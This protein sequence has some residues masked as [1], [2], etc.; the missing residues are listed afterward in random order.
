MLTLKKIRKSFA[1]RRILNGVS[2]SIGDGQRI[3]L[4]GQNGVGKSTLLKIIAGLEEADR[5]DVILKKGALV[6]Y[7]PQETTSSTKETMLDYL[8]N[9]SGLQGI[10]KKMKALEKELHRETIQAE[11][12]DLQ[13][14]YRRLGGFAF[15]DRAKVFLEGLLLS[16]IP[17]ETSVTDLS[18]GQKR[19]LALAGVLLRGVDL[20]LLDEP[21][22]NLDLP[23]LLWL[24][25]FLTLSK[26]TILVASHDRRFLDHVAEKVIEIDMQSRT[27]EMFTGNWSTYSEMKARAV[28]REKELYK[29]Q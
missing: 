4:V 14:E 9:A 18:G 8:R 26:T 1:T 19:K 29:A 16:T 21:T 24:E 12:D 7:L 10:E 3:A 2:F 13:E 28:R 27:A 20:L 6:G 17:L 23:A 15:Q 22:N 11:Y 5:G 25:R